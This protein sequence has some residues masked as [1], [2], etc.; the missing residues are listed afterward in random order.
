[1]LVAL[2]YT[3]IGGSSFSLFVRCV[4]ASLCLLPPTLLMGATLPAMAHWVETTPKGVSWLGFFYGGNIFGAVAG[5]LLAG[6]YLLRHF[7]VSIATFDALALNIAVA[8]GGLAIAKLTPHEHAEGDVSVVRASGAGA[9]YVTIALSG[10]TA[11]AA[12]VI[13]TRI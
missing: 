4:V 9:V 12:E 1:P 3:S 11:L 10:L 5:S 6:F 13:W 2:V 7:D 8:I